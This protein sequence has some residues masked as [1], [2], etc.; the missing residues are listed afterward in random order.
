MHVLVVDDNVD[1][2]EAL[3][4]LL[5]ICGHDVHTVADGPT[6]LEYVARERRPDVVLLDIGLPGID[7]YE[8]ARRL[9]AMPNAAGTRLIAMTGYGSADAREQSQACGIEH[10]LIKPVD[11][12]VLQAVLA[13][14]Q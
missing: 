11:F 2:A 12:S 9:R 5:E 14:S 4:R 3:A 13:G 6:A 1:A 8:V 7:G 10:H